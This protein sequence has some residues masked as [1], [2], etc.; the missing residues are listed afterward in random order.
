[1]IVASIEPL[2]TPLTLLKDILNCKGKIPDNHPLLEVGLGNTERFKKVL[3]NN[4]TAEKVYLALYKSEMGN[5]NAIEE[6]QALVNKANALKPVATIPTTIPSTR[7]DQNFAFPGAPAFS[8]PQPHLVTST[9]T[10]PAKLIKLKGELLN[11]LYA[12]PEKALRWPDL[13]EQSENLIREAGEIAVRNVRNAMD[14]FGNLSQADLERQADRASRKARRRL[15]R[16][17]A[18]DS[19]LSCVQ[20]ATTPF[21][22]MQQVTLLES[23]IP[24]CI[25]FEF[26]EDALSN[27]ANTIADVALRIYVLDRIIAYNDLFGIENAASLTP[28]KLRTQ[29]TC[30]CYASPQCVRFMGHIGKCISAAGSASR[31]PDHFFL[32]PP[33][34]SFSQ[35]ATSEYGLSYQRPVMSMPVDIARRPTPSAP[36][37]PRP[38]REEPLPSIASYADKTHLDIE[39]INPYIPNQTEV[40][41]THWV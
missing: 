4:C 2:Q 30:R 13:D 12:F 38:V 37:V 19:F 34:D 36:M 29:F 31:F 39:N 40:T 11:I 27:V 41:E 17:L 14:R 21:D 25:T 35:Q 23:A 24:K 26:D 1:M 8:K 28:F 16:K 18:L 6:A 7:T 22:L 15:R 20:K 3:N 10:A 9:I 33:E 5:P 32:A